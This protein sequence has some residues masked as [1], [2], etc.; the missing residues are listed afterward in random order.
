ERFLVALIATLGALYFAS[1]V[2]VERMS[3][4]RP[5][6]FIPI[7]LSSTQVAQYSHDPLTIQI[8][9]AR[10]ELIAEVIH[11]Q[12]PDADV[13]AR[14]ATVQANLLTPVAWMITPTPSRT[15]TPT[16]TPTFTATPT[17][18]LTPDPWI[19]LGY[20]QVGCNHEVTFAPVNARRLKFQL[21]S[22][23]G[24]DNH[25][26]FYCCGSS[27]AAFLVNG[28]WVQVT[29]QSSALNVGES[30]ET[31]DV[32]ATVS[33]ARFSVGCNDKEP[34]QVQIFYY[35]ATT[36]ITPVRALTPSATP[37]VRPR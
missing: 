1:V 12:E 4:R 10:L 23:G 17:P 35:P 27:G 3:W 21:L 30:R 6:E 37:T 26:S 28:T 24:K 8:P 11:D 33:R 32:N 16:R 34:V 22:G 9:V 20:A 13:A 29:N 25:V 7:S 36:F 5:A 18:T 19:S 2:F 31:E 15:P 14:F